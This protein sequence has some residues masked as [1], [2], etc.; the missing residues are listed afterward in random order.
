[1]LPTPYFIYVPSSFLLWK[2]G[3]FCVSMS[4]KILR[5][6]SFVASQNLNSFSKMSGSGRNPQKC[7]KGEKSR[8]YVSVAELASEYGSC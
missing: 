3:L 6:A 7:T 5:N 1:M 2:H 4:R 8:L